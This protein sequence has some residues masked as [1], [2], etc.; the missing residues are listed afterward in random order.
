MGN[1]A[2]T[3]SNSDAFFRYDLDTTAGRITIVA[4][5]SYANVNGSDNPV[6]NVGGNWNNG[7]N[8]GVSYLNAN[9]TTSNANDN[10]GSRTI[11][12]LSQI[13]SNPDPG[14]PKQ[15]EEQQLLIRTEREH[16]HVQKTG[17]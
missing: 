16:Q 4:I 2:D 10:V 5:D 13:H 8:A 11:S 6:A 14:E 7:S 9:Y 3:D 12:A 15:V 17:L 1:G